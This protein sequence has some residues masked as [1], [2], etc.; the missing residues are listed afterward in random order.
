[1]KRVEHEYH[2]GFIVD[3]SS[4]ASCS[5]ERKK[6]E[7]FFSHWARETRNSG[8]PTV[9][10]VAVDVIGKH[11][12]LL[13]LPCPHIKVEET[14]GRQQFIKGIRSTPG[15][16][17]FIVLARVWYRVDAGSTTLYRTS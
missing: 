9:V 17:H 10:Q 16:Q 1:M 11:I 4:S 2:Y 5:G 12:S 7:G 14:P 15:R 3:I 13:L 8:I 6:K